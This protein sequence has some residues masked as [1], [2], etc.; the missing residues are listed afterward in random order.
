MSTTAMAQAPQDD[1]RRRRTIVL[2]LVHAGLAL[3]I[4]AGFVIAQMHRGG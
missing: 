4:L 3:V 1:A 2:A